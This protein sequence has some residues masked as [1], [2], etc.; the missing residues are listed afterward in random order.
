[1]SENAA[2][3]SRENDSVY[4]SLPLSFHSPYI[5][6][7]WVFS[8]NLFNRAAKTSGWFFLI[9]MV[10]MR[11]LLYKDGKFWKFVQTLTSDCNTARISLL[12]TKPSS[13]I[14]GKTARPLS[15]IRP[16]R[17]NLRQRSLL[18]SDHLQF[19][20]RGVKRWI[21]V[22]SSSFFVV[23]SILPKHIA[24]STASIYQKASL[25]IGQPRLTTSQHSFSV[26]WLF[27]SHN[28][29]SSRFFLHSAGWNASFFSYI[30]LN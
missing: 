26:E 20:L 17:S 4:R 25:P 16:K 13:D 28:L 3:L 21:V 6:P 2:D 23:L 29:N 1:M 7:F 11:T 8:T 18:S 27:S 30:G 9:C 14:S 24:S 15:V 5:T 12:I 19:L 10:S 22:P